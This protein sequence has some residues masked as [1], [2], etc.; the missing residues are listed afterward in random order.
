M[1]FTFYEGV[2]SIE[3]FDLP[4]FDFE[5]EENRYL[6]KT[7]LKGLKSPTRIPLD[8]GE[9]REFKPE[10]EPANAIDFVVFVVDA[11]TL[12]KPKQ[13][14]WSSTGATPQRLRAYQDTFALLERA[15]K[16]L[17]QTQHSTTTTINHI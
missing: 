15:G 10:F 4:G 12:H 6:L 9:F 8:K 17:N 13:N 5:V 14:R 3:C 16:Q 2:G 11:T 1:L 7:V